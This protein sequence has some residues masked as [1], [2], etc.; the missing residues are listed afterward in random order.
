MS[1][2][3]ILHKIH[4]TI[5]FLSVQNEMKWFS[6]ASEETKRWKTGCFYFICFSSVYDILQHFFDI[7]SHCCDSVFL[8]VFYL[9]CM[10][11][12]MMSLANGMQ[13]QSKQQQKKRIM[14][15]VKTINWMWI[16][17]LVH[18]SI[19]L[20]SVSFV[21]NGNGNIWNKIRTSVK[22]WDFRPFFFFYWFLSFQQFYF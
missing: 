22:V 9:F 20:M 12:T 19:R 16:N 1:G 3:N 5:G 18:R 7:Y 2:W 21:F 17:D 8:F 14:D 10:E 4:F 13:G 11:C 15:R 6:R